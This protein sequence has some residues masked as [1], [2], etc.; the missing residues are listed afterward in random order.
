MGPARPTAAGPLSRC[1]RC[2]RPECLILP[3]CWSTSKPPGSAARTRGASKGG[4][5]SPG[6][7]PL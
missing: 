7:W 6:R 4:R 2:A 1:R 5:C 3:R